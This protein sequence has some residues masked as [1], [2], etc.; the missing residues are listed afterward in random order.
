[1]M[2]TPN[3]PCEIESI[4]TAMRAAIG[5]G[6]VNTAQVAKSWIRLV[7]EARPAIR[8]NDSRL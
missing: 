7:T 2:F 1:M 3:R 4:V 8:V 6:R 5:G